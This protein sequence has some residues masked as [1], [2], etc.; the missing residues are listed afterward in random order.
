MNDEPARFR[1]AEYGSPPSDAIPGSDVVGHD[2]HWS[3]ALNFD[4]LLS[5]GRE[6]REQQ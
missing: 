1:F 2:R 3:D 4:V 5:A 6:R